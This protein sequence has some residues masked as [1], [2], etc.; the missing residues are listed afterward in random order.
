MLLFLLLQ[1]LLFV[2]VTIIVSTLIVA[3]AFVFHC[4]H[5]YGTEN[6]IINNIKIIIVLRIIT[7]AIPILI[8]LSS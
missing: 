3:V 8:L 5:N 1:L 6:V 7:V 4:T 2:I